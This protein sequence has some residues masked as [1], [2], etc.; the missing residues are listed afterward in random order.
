[1]A[2]N[3]NGDRLHRAGSSVGG[4]FCNPSV[5]PS[6]LRPASFPKAVSSKKRRRG[7]PPARHS[8]DHGRHRALQA[9]RCSSH[10]KEHGLDGRK[11][12]KCHGGSAFPNRDKKH[13]FI[14]SSECTI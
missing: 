4:Y 12:F 13:L 6:Q 2:L 11:C 7:P 14:N 3:P 8:P 10:V 9:Q 5:T 1:M